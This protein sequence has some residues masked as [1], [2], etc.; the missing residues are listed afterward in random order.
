[1]EDKIRI[2]HVFGR[3]GRGGAET[4]LMNIYRNID[5]EKIQFD[6]LVH[7]TEEC[8]YDREILALG[9]KIHRVP[10][11]K[12]SNHFQYIKAWHHFFQ[13]NSCYKIIHSH[14]R[15]TA[16]IYL[17]IANKYGLTTI[18]H[19]H[20]TSSGTGMSALMKNLLQHNIKHT[21][22]YL[23]AC[24]KVAGEWLFGKKACEENN[25]FLINNAID[26]E[27]FRFNPQTRLDKRKEIKVADKFVI[28]HV[29]R[30]HP[31]K[32]HDFLIDIFQ[33]IHQQNQDAVLLLVGDGEL[34]REIELK[35]ERLGLKENVIFGGIRADVPDLLQAMDVFLFPS[36][37]EGLPVTLVETQAACLPSVVSDSITREVELTDSINY[38]SL[39]HSSSYWAEE[40]LKY[41][42]YDLRNND[43]LQS[44]I[45]NGYDIVS[46]SKWYSEFINEKFKGK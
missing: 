45:D 24:S 29:G 18:A 32:N 1:M 15:S 37:Y 4:M 16:S 8:D 34:R 44:I 35:V 22:D 42:H 23:F 31:Q 13:T 10:K 25:F 21:A 36:L 9:G 30:F 27:K 38:I 39:Q 6:F 41:A 28:G 46:V 11:Y 33:V 7:T 20:N 19:S 12:G 2:L 17:K 26:T 40:V 3:M 5:R 14:V 43:V